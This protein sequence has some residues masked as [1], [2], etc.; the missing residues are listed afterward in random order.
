MG[1]DL[2]GGGDDNPLDGTLTYE[3]EGPSDAQ[4][5]LAR[6]FFYVDEGCQIS[7]STTESVPSEGTLAP[8]APSGES[9]TTCSDVDLNNFD[10]V[11]VS[12]TFPPRP[13][14]STSLTVRLLSD[15]NVEDEARTPTQ[16]RT[17]IV[18]LGTIPEQDDQTPF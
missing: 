18:E 4:V 2:F 10:G 8:Q 17:W 12:V 6:T 14:Q 15:G 3:I 7:R 9:G 13:G 5:A 1:C 11:Q 16:G